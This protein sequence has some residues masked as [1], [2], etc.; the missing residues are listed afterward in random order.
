[1]TLSSTIIC[2]LT[3]ILQQMYSL[4]NNSAKAESSLPSFNSPDFTAVHFNALY[5]SRKPL[6]SYL[7]KH[8]YCRLEEH[9]HYARTRIYIY[10]RISGLD[11]GMIYTNNFTNNL[12]LFSQFLKLRLH[13]FK[14]FSI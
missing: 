10:R 7:V 3:T 14:C 4:Q 6:T 13:L 8:I 12:L 11:K 2:S 1:M 9:N 5:Y